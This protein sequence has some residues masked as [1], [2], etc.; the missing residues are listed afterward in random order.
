MIGDSAKEYIMVNTNNINK[1]LGLQ[2]IKAIIEQSV[3]WRQWIWSV[4]KGFLNNQTVQI[5]CFAKQVYVWGVFP[6][7]DMCVAQEDYFTI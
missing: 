2:T 1:I 3:M 6:I 7:R 4:F 5:V